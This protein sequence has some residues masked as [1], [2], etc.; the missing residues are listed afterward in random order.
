MILHC[1]RKSIKIPLTKII[2][3]KTTRFPFVLVTVNCKA[4]FS[5][6]AF[7]R[8]LATPSATSSLLTTDEVHEIA[9]MP[10][11]HARSLAPREEKRL[12]LADPSAPAH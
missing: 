4:S 11:L 12:V 7:A 9:Q 5:L 6:V 3:G 2:P 1:S 8:N 10:H